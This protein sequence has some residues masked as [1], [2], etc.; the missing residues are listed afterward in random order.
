MYIR[1]S[2][3]DADIS[4]NDTKLESNSVSN[5]RDLLMDFI[6]NHEELADYNILE[7]CDDGYSGTNFERP[8][9]QKLLA[10]VKQREID[11]IVV[12]DFSRFGRSYLEL[13]DYLEQVFP[14]L[15]VHFISVNDGYD[16]VRDNG[17]TAGLDIGLKNLIYDLYSKD[18]SQK[19]RTAKIAKMKKGEYIG[20]F[21]PYGYLKVKNKKNAIV[22]D[23]EAALVV[24]KIFKLASEGN[25]TSTIAKILN[26]EGV[27]SPAKHFQNNHNNKKWRNKE[28]LLWSSMAILKILRDETYLGK[29]VNHKRETPDVNSKSTAA[30][31]KDEWIVIPN[32]HEAIISEDIFNEA[33]K[34]IRKIS[35]RKG[36]KIDS[37]RI[38]YGKVKCG[39]CKK[40]LHRSHTKDIYYICNSN[41][42]TENSSCFK[43]RIKESL[44]LEVLLETIRQQAQIANKAEELVQKLNQKLE[45]ELSLLLQSIRKSQ[46]YLER[47]NALKIEEY[48]KYLDEQISKEEYLK[49]R[50]QY[51]SEIEETTLQIKKLETDYELQKL[52]NSESENQ[53]VEHFKS[54]QE[55]KELTRELV[56]ELVSSIY[57]YSEKEIEIVW[58]FADDYARVIEAMQG[59][60]EE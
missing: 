2:N 21:A 11:C 8:S 44:I 33:Q 24:K 29:T 35:K 50:E 52:K 31:P 46:E 47:L 43:E 34:A 6:S 25:N 53:F 59:G 54:M 23:K 14:F 39:I 4:I 9:V 5:Q 15:G 41:Y 56:D 60:S 58:N 30:V 27:P 36:Y 32:T 57:V 49:Q 19:V 45:D 26:A 42:Y 48:E 16:S 10:K 13:G 7:F 12:K 55:I 51:N 38:L 37:T 1:L 18:L 17:S 28:N 3:E 22:V 40:T 20:S